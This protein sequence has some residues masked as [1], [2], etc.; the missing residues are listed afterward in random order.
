MASVKSLFKRT[1]LTANKKGPDSTLT[2]YLMVF[3]LFAIVMLAGIAK[4]Y[5]NGKTNTLRLHSEKTQLEVDIILKE[6]NNLLLEKETYMGGKYILNKARAM[7]LQP[8]LPL[9]VR[10]MA[11]IITTANR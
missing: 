4:V 11:P 2:T 5:I 6:R 10:K 3:L 8:P 9:Q 7:G 1:R